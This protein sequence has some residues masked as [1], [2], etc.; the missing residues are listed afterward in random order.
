MDRITLSAFLWRWERYVDNL[1]RCRLTDQR[2]HL[3]HS[4]PGSDCCIAQAGLANRFLHSAGAQFCNITQDP[5]YALFSVAYLC[6]LALFDS[7][8]GLPGDVIPFTNLVR[9]P[10]FTEE[11]H[12]LTIDFWPF[13]QQPFTGVPWPGII[14]CC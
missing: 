8:Y 2:E 11:A 4:D 6:S 12:Y 7:P 14:P 10:S 13:A 1:Q 9:R 5:D 3:V